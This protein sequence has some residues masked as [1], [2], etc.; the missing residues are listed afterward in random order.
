LVAVGPVVA[1]AVLVGAV[2]LVAVEVI[3]GGGVFVAVA[4]FVG[5]GV[6]V[7]VAVLVGPTVFVG[8][9]PGGLVGV[10]RTTPP[11]SR[12]GGMFAGLSFEALRICGAASGGQST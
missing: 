9:A 2:V 12:I 11:R 6:L 10:T 5:T 7:R 1:V 4:V 3:V 8:L